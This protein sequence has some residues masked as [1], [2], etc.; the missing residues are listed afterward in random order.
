GR[1]GGGELDE[2]KD[3]GRA[4]LARD[5]EVVARPF[6]HHVRL[7]LA[8][9]Q[10]NWVLDAHDRVVSDRTD[11]QSVEPIDT[12]NVGITDGHL[13]N[14]LPAN[15]LDPVVLL[16]DAEVDHLLVGCDRE[17]VWSSPGGHEIISP[18]SRGGMRCLSWMGLYQ[19][20]RS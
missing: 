6:Q 16:E 5:V 2:K 18:E 10:A 1:G 19:R 11:Q 4:G 12:G 13:C 8:V 9:R 14:D 17:T 20:I 3:G 7:R 15:E